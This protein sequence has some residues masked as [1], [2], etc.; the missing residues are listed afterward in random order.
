MLKLR[1]WQEKL[2]GKVVEALRSK[3]VVLL[4]APTGSGKTLFSLLV[5]FDLF[6]RVIA[7]VKTHNE[8][9]PY[10][11]EAKRLGKRFSFLVG[12]PNACL[13]AS[14]DVD[15][16]DIKCGLCPF[17][18]SV[19]IE[20]QS[21]PAEFLSQLKERGGNEGF[22]PYY[23]LQDSLSKAEVVAITYPYLLVPWYRAS[24]D[25]PLEESLVVID[26]AHNL[27]RAADL[28]ERVLSQ[29]SLEGALRE[30]SSQEAR[31]ILGSI[32]KSLQGLINQGEKY[33]RVTNVSLVS[34]DELQVLADELEDLREKMIKERRIRRLHLGSVVKFLVATRSPDYVIYSAEGK[35]IARSFAPLSEFK[36]IVENAGGLLL[37]SGTLPPKNYLTKVLDFGGKDV[38]EFNAE[39]FV[40]LRSYEAFDCYI[41]IDVTSKYELR[42]TMASKYASYLLRIYYSAKSHVLAVSPSYEYMNAITSRLKIPTYVESEESPVESLAKLNERTLICAVSRG[43]LTEG[44]ELVDEE[45]RSRISD[46]AVVGIPYPPVD[47]LTEDF[48]NRAGIPLH[49]FLRINAWIAVRQAVGRAIRG[50]EDRAN[51][52]LLDRRFEEMWWR[53]SLNCLNPRRV[54]L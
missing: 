12:K 28:T 51:L 36:D 4:N 52:W 54:R 40:R 19:E 10:Y 50:P 3:K 11:R 25:V 43:K 49:E 7:G 1:D 2:K 8:F 30:V 41:A 24:I 21:S 45:G 38:V 16:E 14:K 23:T 33:V 27:D 46:V 47:D 42:E 32:R 17:R 35:L 13:F 9:F 5:G 15:S 22:C 37:M 53:K 34:H 29:R 31:S 48:S 6:D 44:I 39:K 20:A 26:E 18:R